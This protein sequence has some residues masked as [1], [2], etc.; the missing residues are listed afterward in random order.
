M[1]GEGQ[2]EVSDDLHGRLDALDDQA[3]AA[4]RGRRR[5][6]APQ[7]ARADARAS[8]GPRGTRLAD[9]DLGASDLIIPPSDLSLDEARE[10]FTDGGLIPDLPA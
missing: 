8:S 5:G 10:L 3:A 6:G 1:G 9:D 2:F 4:A 7:R